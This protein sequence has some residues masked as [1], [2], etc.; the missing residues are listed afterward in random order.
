[1]HMQSD[2]RE[3][4]GLFAEIGADDLSVLLTCLGARSKHY[5]KKEIV[6]LVEDRVDCVGI[7]VRGALM[8]IKEDFAGSR[9]IIDRI[10]QYEIFGESLVCAG[11]AT[12]PVTVVAAEDTEIMWIQFN[13]ILSTCTSSCAFHTRLIGNMIKSLAVR[14]LQ[15]NLKMEVTSKRNIRDKLMSYLLQH[16]ERSRSFDFIIPLNRSELADYIY[17]DRSALSRELSR[18]KDEGMIDFKKN[19]FRILNKG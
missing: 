15:M 5:K 18:M 10:E 13:R 16:A 2:L 17:V 1:M 14:N 11:I 8:V 12:S 9:S 19:H 6:L 4:V 7:V 3:N